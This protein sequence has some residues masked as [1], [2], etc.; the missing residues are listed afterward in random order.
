MGTGIYRSAFTESVN[1]VCVP[2]GYR[3]IPAIASKYKFDL[4]RS[5]WVQGYTAISSSYKMSLKA[6]PVGT[7]IY[8]YF[9]KKRKFRNGVP[10]GYRD[11]P[12]IIK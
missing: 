8:R 10:C 9:Y 6:F 3:D 4:Q 5:L 2:C 1:L 7:G 11:I 12:A